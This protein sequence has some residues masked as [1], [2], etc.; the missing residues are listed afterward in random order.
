MME[1]VES[2]LDLYNSKFANYLIPLPI[3]WSNF[4]P[5]FLLPRLLLV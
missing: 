4:D 1:I 3:L 2:S 5:V